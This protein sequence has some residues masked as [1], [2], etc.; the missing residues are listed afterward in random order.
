MENMYVV[1][2]DESDATNPGWCISRPANYS[3]GMDSDDLTLTDGELV[4]KAEEDLD[5]EGDGPG[6]ILVDR[7]GA[8]GLVVEHECYGLTSHFA[9]IAEAESAYRE[10]GIKAK[11][12]ER[13][14]FIFDEKNRRVGW[15]CWHGDPH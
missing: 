8:P 9:T 13:S 10:C 12:E 15:E 11:F 2:W 1:Y 4:A 3:L 6:I 7:S 5:D 14:G